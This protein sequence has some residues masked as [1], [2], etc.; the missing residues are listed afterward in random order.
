M[1]E[2]CIKNQF[3]VKEQKVLMEKGEAEREAGKTSQLSEE[4]V[5]T[6]CF[7]LSLAHLSPVFN[8]NGLLLEIAASLW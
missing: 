5:V 3:T 7:C 8:Y 2:C 1:S 6:A 4:S